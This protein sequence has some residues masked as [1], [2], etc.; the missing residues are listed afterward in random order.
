MPANTGHTSKIMSK[1]GGQKMVK[2]MGRGRGLKRG[3]Y[4]YKARDLYFD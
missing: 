2:L 1:N 4:G 3:K